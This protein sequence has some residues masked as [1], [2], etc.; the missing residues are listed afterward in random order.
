[1]VSGYRLS[2]LIA[3]VGLSASLACSAQGD[4]E[5]NQI[6][7]G[8]GG[9]STGTNNG[10]S[11]ILG[12][13]SSTNGGAGGAIPVGGNGTSGSGGTQGVLCEGQGSRLKG[14]LRD[15]Q[16]GS[17]P[18]QHPDFEPHMTKPTAI[19]F[20]NAIE[21]GIVQPMVDPVAWIPLYAGPLGGTNTTM[22][23]AYFP[24]WFLDDPIVNTTIDYWIEFVGPDAN[25]VYTFDRTGRQNGFWPVDDGPN[26]PVMPQTP[27]LR[28]NST[29][30]PT[31]NYALTFELHTNFVYRPGMAFTFTGDDDVWV[32]INNRL[33]LDL[34]GIHMQTSGTINLDQIAAEFG[35]TPG[36][37]NQNDPTYRLDF[38]WAERHVTDSNFRIDTTLDFR[39]CGIDPVR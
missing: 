16:P 20:Y 38:F 32:F 33:A 1:M 9:S 36:T 17:G 39:D 18:G 4:Q 30:Y 24:S 26:C 10:G 29:N 3:F 8:A 31:H 23:P 34:G 25:G 15:F 13:T 11:P 21:R 7:D 35:L 2:A 6:G 37:G 19:N 12:G 22:G 28:G 14:K 27:C 5:A